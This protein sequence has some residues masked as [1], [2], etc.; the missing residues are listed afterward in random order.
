MAT[1][2]M[3][4]WWWHDTC[5]IGE[6]GRPLASPQPPCVPDVQLVLIWQPPCLPGV[7]LRGEKQIVELVLLPKRLSH[8]LHASLH[9]CN[10]SLQQ[11]VHESDRLMRCPPDA[12]TPQLAAS[13]CPSYCGAQEGH[14][15]GPAEAPHLPPPRP[16]LASRRPSPPVSRAGPPHG[17]IGRGVSVAPPATRQATR[18]LG[19]A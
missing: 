2:L 4:R 7:Q 3:R 9:L 16:Q 14:R 19:V 12:R 8:N 17:C 5:T 15:A 6:S 11:L 18:S 13:S 10:A 1:V